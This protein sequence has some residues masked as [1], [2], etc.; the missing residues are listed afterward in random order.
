MTAK[1]SFDW[2]GL[3]AV[4]TDYKDTWIGFDAEELVENEDN[5]LVTDEEGNFGLFEFS[6]PGIYYGH[7]MFTE[8]GPRTEEIARN[9]LG[10]FFKEFPVTLVLGMTPVEHK[11]ALNLNRK[12]G[13]TFQGVTD[14]GAGPH[15][16]VSLK[17]EDFN[18][19]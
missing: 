6:R 7:Y 16:I 14:T 12:L 13:F 9:L 19:G 5:I 3:D 4:V 17:K 8:R 11:G 1:R 18:Y 10:F 15:F 2:E